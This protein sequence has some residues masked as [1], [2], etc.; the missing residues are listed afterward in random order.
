[1]ISMFENINEDLILIEEK[2]EKNNVII[3]KEFDP[4]LEFIEADKQRIK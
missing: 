4:Q 2:A 1:M 3:K